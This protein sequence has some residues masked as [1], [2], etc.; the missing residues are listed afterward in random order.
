MMNIGHTYPAASDMDTVGSPIKYS[1]CVAE[2][3][4]ASPWDPYHVERGFPRDTSTV[5]VQFVYGICDLENF[6]STE[7]EALCDVYATSATNASAVTTGMWLVGRRADPRHMVEAKEHDVLFICPDHAAIFAR[8]GWRKDDIR[9]YLFAKARLP[10]RTLMLPQEPAQMR[11]SH[12]ELAWLW[13]Q[14]DT[15]LPVLETP[16]CFDIVVVGAS[17][18]RGAFF[19]GAGEPV[20]KPVQH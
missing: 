13:D 2:N 8:R 3:E 1:L 16:D 14:P 9:R 20:T 10:F 6:V 7:P 19:W 11:R 12:P 17:A 4:R 5:T 15:L 18:G